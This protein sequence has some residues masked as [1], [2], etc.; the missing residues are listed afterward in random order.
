MYRYMKHLYVCIDIYNPPNIYQNM[1]KNSLIITPSRIFKYLN[2]FKT[3]R[4]SVLHD[5]TLRPEVSEDIHGTIPS[6]VPKH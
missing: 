4:N 3:L 5:K 2:I 6:T 1:P